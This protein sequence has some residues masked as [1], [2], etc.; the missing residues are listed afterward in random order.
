MKMVNDEELF[1]IIKMRDE[2]KRF[3]LSDEKNILDEKLEYWH[4]LL[5]HYI[6]IQVLQ[7][8]LKDLEKKHI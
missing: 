5:A 2:L 6:D 4:E 3:I 1:C 8:K 7:E